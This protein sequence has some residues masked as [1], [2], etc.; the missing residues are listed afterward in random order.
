MASSLRPKHKRGDSAGYQPVYQEDDGGGS[1]PGVGDGV[2][3]AGAEGDESGN[4]DQGHESRVV[5]RQD[6]F[7]ARPSRSENRFRMATFVLAFLLV[8]LVGAN[9]FLF[10][11]AAFKGSDDACSCRPKDVPQYFQTS[12]ELWAG[13]T[14]TG[15]SPFMGQTRVF[16]PTATYVPP[17]PL[18]TDMPIEGGSGNESIFKMMGFLSPYTPSP[19]FGVDE[20]PLP[21]GANILQVQMLSRH[22]SRYPTS[23]SEVARFGEKVANVSATFK[24]KGKL[25]FLHD[26]KYE[27]GAEILVPKGR[28][29]LFE[30]GKRFIYR[31]PGSGS[32]LMTV[33]SAGVLHNYM[34]GALYNPNSKIIVRTTVSI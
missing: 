30:S 3:G 23:G 1:E 32:K 15:K 2:A 24:P 17:E 14:P 8:L 19:G 22:G 7:L 20:F 13:P 9:A 33:H 10:L 25:A 16:D 18:Q 31:P 6:E 21:A 12:P 11:P 28:E 34:Y 4:A 5:A 26:W 27:L 29:E